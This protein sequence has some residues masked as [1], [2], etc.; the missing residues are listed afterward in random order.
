MEDVPYGRILR[1]G[2]LIILIAAI[3]GAGAAYGVAK[4]LPETYAA[5]STLLLQVDSTEASLF[6]RSQFSL[7]R[8][9]TYPA[10]VDSPEVVDGIRRDL[11]LSE[12]EYSDRDI[13]RMLSAENT[14]D[15]VLLVVRADAPTAPLAADMANAAARNLSTLIETTENSDDDDRYRV[16]MNQ[17]LPAVEPQA[18][19]SPQ[20]TAITGLGLIAGLAL[21]AIVAV[22]RTT[23]SRRLSTISDVRRASGLPVVGQIPRRPRLSI[24]ATRERSDAA[25]SA[26]YE[27]T[28]GSLTALGGLGITRYVFVPT[29]EGDI[30]DDTID[31]L[32]EAF[33]ASGRRACL[34]DARAA[35][36]A[37]RKV[38]PL[39]NVLDPEFAATADTGRGH[40]HIVYAASERIPMAAL[41]ET[42]PAAMVRLG[43]TFDIVLL[44]TDPGAAGLIE[45]VAATGAGVVLTVR[46]NETSATDLISVTTRLRVMDVHPLGVLMT[47]ASP[48]AIGVV[49]ES[50]RESD[51]NL[52][53]SHVGSAAVATTTAPRRPAAPAA[54]PAE[55]DVV[56][57][58]I[59]EEPEDDAPSGE[60]VDEDATAEEPEELAAEAAAESDDEDAAA[61]D[62]ED[63]A[64]DTPAVLSGGKDRGRAED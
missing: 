31:G 14:A 13:R 22:Y 39:E 9:K 32:L 6:E 48:R 17:V 46:H 50:W 23:T 54:E 57:D 59:A 60:A 43:T 16:T 64:D 15:T 36:P 2:W 27:D 41:E 61:D 25:E 47:Q 49:A 55:Q 3:L 58:L 18:P 4:L 12:K 52:V 19:V 44:L 11:G 5:T 51:R 30:D 26:A 10:L 21:G 7:A 40:G 38:K 24:S 53:A 33:I 63:A 37:G 45:A 1:E 35:V 20:V 62:D 29:A 42:V 34:L 28:L 56:D 8:I